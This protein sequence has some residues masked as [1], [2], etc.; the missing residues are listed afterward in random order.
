MFAFPTDG[1]LEF[2]GTSQDGFVIVG[3]G[4]TT[5]TPC[6]F[7]PLLFSFLFFHSLGA[8]SYLL[9]H[10]LSQPFF[11]EKKKT[12][13]KR[14]A[15]AQRLPTKQNTYPESGYHVKIRIHTKRGRP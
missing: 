9:L 4:Q 11:F 12:I 8:I 1:G 2:A 5:S 10:V 13:Y 3:G 6:C 7:P 14:R 15:S